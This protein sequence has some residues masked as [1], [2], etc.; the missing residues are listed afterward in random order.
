MIKVKLVVRNGVTIHTYV[1]CFIVTS[2]LPHTACAQKKKKKIK[3]SIK[4]EEVI[5][6][7]ES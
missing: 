5:R 6:E 4:R 7:M 2:N 1:S 3:I